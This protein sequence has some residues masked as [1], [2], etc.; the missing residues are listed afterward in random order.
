MKS[1]PELQSKTIDF[2]RFPLSIAVIFIHMAPTVKGSTINWSSL[3]GIDLYAIIAVLCS[4]ILSATVV[5]T[6]FLFSGFLFFLGF[7]TWSKNYY[8]G[9]MK[10]RIKT[11]LIPFILWN[12]IAFMSVLGK[13]IGLYVIKGDN[14]IFDY[15]RGLW[16][17]GSFIKLFWNSGIGGGELNWF[18]SRIPAYFPSDYPLWFLRDLIVVSLLAPLVYYLV[19][20]MKQYG[21]ILLGLFYVT[22]VWF[23]IAGFSINALFFFSI[24]AYFS[25]NGKNLIDSLRTTKIPFYILA[26]L[27]II[28]YIYFDGTDTAIY[29][30]PFFIIAGVISIMNLTADLLEK[31]NYSISNTLVKSSFF[32]YALHGILV[33]GSCKIIYNKLFSPVSPLEITI[34]YLLVPF[35]TAGVCLVFFLLMKRFC[36]KTLGVL[37]GS[38][39]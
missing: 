1:G 26:F 25:I 17:D 19:K 23:P 27:S 11:L 7:K 36:P 2:L 37:T 33:L 39:F 22:G 14:A 34:G 18:G 9:K 31:K 28:P 10:K 21:L 38:R 29:F 6:F 32:V 13:K 5:P 35:I 4:R 15:L 12:L 3:S 24:G 16:T 30:K 8:T 20:Y